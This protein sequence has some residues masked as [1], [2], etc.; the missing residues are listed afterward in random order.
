M[1]TE[2]R[3]AASLLKAAQVQAGA[4]EKAPRKAKSRPALRRGPPKK[5]V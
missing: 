5:R 3:I 1:K 2:K 4:S